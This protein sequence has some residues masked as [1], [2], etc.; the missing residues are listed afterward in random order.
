MT[1][2]AETLALAERQLPDRLRLRDMRPIEIRQRVVQI[3]VVDVE[4]RA[5]GGLSVA[6]PTTVKAGSN[7]RVSFER[8]NV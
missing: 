5:R 7:D 8:E 4:R 3:A 1:L 6:V 2:A